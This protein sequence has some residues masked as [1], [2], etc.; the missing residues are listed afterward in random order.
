MQEAAGRGDAP[1]F[2]TAA[3]AALQHTLAATWQ[4]P[5]DQITLADV[6]ARLGNDGDDIREIFALADEA[7]YSGD[8][9]Q[10][11]DFQRWID[12]VRGRLTRGTPA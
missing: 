3:R 6:D 10:A 2:F 7:N 4:I 1:Q 9:L 12:T 11:T 5:A 8:A